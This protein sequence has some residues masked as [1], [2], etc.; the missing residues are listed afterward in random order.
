M[1][2]C[3]V[4]EKTSTILKT[5]ITEE[6]QRCS[7]HPTQLH[8]LPMEMAPG[9]SME[10]KKKWKR[11]SSDI[12]RGRATS[13]KRRLLTCGVCYIP[14]WPRRRPHLECAALRRLCCWA[15][16]LNS[17]S[18][19]KVGIIHVEA[20]H[21]RCTRHALLI[22]GPLIDVISD[23]SRF[24]PTLFWTSCTPMPTRTPLLSLGGAGES[25]CSGELS[26]KGFS[27]TQSDSDISLQ[28]CLNRTKYQFIC[29]S[30]MNRGGIFNNC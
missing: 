22:I 28:L 17:R 18:G 26:D 5:Y 11:K 19:N 6:V 25:N 7:A 2:D 21:S 29:S 10:I 3:D 9:A 15:A 14:S 8:Q 4:S 13:F 27:L 24:F 23:L 1:D 30:T 20:S 16:R 12:C